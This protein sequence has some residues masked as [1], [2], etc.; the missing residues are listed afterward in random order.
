MILFN[1]GFLIVA[2]GWIPG[3]TLKKTSSIDRA[4]MFSTVA[5]CALVLIA[6]VPGMRGAFSGDL[7]FFPWRIP[8]GNA[9]FS[10][11][12][13]S[14]F[15]LFIIALISG[16]AAV[17]A[18]AYLR[19]HGEK[20][21]RSKSHWFF[22]QLLVASMM[23]VVVAQNAVF[24]M[25][26]WE[27]MSLSSFFLVEFQSEKA[28]VRRAGWMYLV[29]THIGAA[30]LLAMFAL[31]ARHAGSFDF[32]AFREAASSIPSSLSGII[33]AFGLVGF[34]MKA[35]FFPAHIWLPEAHPQ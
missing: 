24:F 35:G 1:A 7:Y 23:I 34:G 22:Y 3:L 25:L 5:G 8:F 21:A 30:F 32:R 6:S 29:F 10:L 17:Y 20:P 26:A 9:L 14:S 4:G 19:H 12:P 13:L 15:F 18:P 11:A 28:D 27:L 31:L 33:F 2:L 16:L